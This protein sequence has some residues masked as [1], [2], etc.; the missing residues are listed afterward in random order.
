VFA[1]STPACQLSTLRKMES[2]TEY[3]SG[4]HSIAYV[5]APNDE[6]AKKIGRGLVENKLAACVNII[7]QITSMYNKFYIKI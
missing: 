5:T 6:T 7:P 1:T 3:K 4:T 2:N